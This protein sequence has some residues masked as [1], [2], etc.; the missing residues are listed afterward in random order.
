MAQNWRPERMRRL[1][2]IAFLI[3]AVLFGELA[4]LAWQNRSEMIV[5]GDHHVLFLIVAAICVLTGIVLLT[6]IKP[7][8]R[9]PLAEGSKK[10][11][12]KR[13]EEPAREA[14]RSTNKAA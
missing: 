13:P 9:H 12:V 10:N 7:A 1:F 6:H 14:P 2:G 5:A 8:D 4:Y 3:S 11:D